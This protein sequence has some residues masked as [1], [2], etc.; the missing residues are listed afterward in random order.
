MIW[1]VLTYQSNLHL[2][3]D[4][5]STVMSFQSMGTSLVSM[6]A[7]PIAGICMDGMGIEL[8]Y[9]GFGIFFIAVIIVQLAWSKGCSR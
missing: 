3:S 7:D 4:I 5:R 2:K 8:F 1:P 9:L 6:A